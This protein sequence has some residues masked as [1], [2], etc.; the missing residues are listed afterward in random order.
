MMFPSIRAE[1]AASRL[2]PLRSMFF[3]GSLV[4]GLRGLF[5]LQ[6]RVWV[7]SVLPV[8]RYEC[9]IASDCDFWF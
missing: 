8:L 3:G 2:S 4:L 7:D 9:G 5:A 6:R 1:C